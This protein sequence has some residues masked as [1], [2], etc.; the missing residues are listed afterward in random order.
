MARRLYLSLIGIVVL[1]T[2]AIGWFGWDQI[3]DR[4]AKLK[5]AQGVVYEARLDFWKDSSKIIR[6]FKL[7]GSGLGTFSHIYPPYKSLVDNLE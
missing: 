3:L 5:N 4:F 1:A 7:T 6:D 2:L